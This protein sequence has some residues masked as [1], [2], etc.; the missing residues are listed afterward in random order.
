MNLNNYINDENILQIIISIILSLPTFIINS[1]KLW[2]LLKTE[3]LFTQKI[4]RQRKVLFI[5]SVLYIIILVISFPRMHNLYSSFSEDYA[6]FRAIY[7]Y[8]ILSF[9][10]SI[11][12]ILS[13]QSSIFKLPYFFALFEIIYAGLIME[14]PR[15]REF[16]LLVESISAIVN[17]SSFLILLLSWRRYRIDG[18]SINDLIL[19]IKKL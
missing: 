16:H 13:K 18:G 1:L 7:F 2:K 14:F 19:G 12:H 17:N 10:F 15:L 11:W 3:I 9:Y 8:L 4:E 6:T 5:T